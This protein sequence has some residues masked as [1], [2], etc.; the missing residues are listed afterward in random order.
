MDEHWEKRGKIETPLLK[1]R[2]GACVRQHPVYFSLEAEETLLPE[3]FRYVGDGI[4]STPLIFPTG[5]LSFQKICIGYRAVKIF[6]TKQK[7]SYCTKMPRRFTR[8]SLQ[9]FNRRMIMDPQTFELKTPYL[10]TGRS[11]TVLAQTDLMN[12]AIKYYYEGGENTLHTHP[13]EDHVFIVMDGEATFYDKEDKATVL[14]KGMGILLPK[15]WY[16]RFHNTGGKPLIILRFGADK[17]KA[18]SH[19]PES[20]ANRCPLNRAKTT[21]L[22]HSPSKG[23]S[24]LYKPLDGENLSSSI[25]CFFFPTEKNLTAAWIFM[26]GGKARTMSCKDFS[27]RSK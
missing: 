14:A 2:P 12:V 4:S 5:I 13:T 25:G 6:P 9:S 21:L 23:V 17:D 1:Q 20:K 3:T 8:S 16:Y 15:G 11:H 26:D 19:E 24:G 27:L 10:K 7:I 22:N 18:S